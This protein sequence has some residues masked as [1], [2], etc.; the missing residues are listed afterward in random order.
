MTRTAPRTP[1]ETQEAVARIKFLHQTMY[2]LTIR[3]GRVAVRVYNKVVE[4]VEH[5]NDHELDCLYEFLQNIHDKY[6]LRVVKIY[7]MPPNPDSAWDH[8]KLLKIEGLQE[9]RLMVDA[10]NALYEAW[11]KPYKPTRRI[12]VPKDKGPQ[13]EIPA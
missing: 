5:M 11:R 10:G 3:F 1:E 9:Q 13:Q 2:D 4:K 12:Y 6:Y 8:Y 7:R